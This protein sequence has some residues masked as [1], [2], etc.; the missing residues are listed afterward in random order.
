MLS[1]KMSSFIAITLD[2]D[3]D[4]ALRLIAQTGLAHFSDI[5]QSSRNL[6]Q[7]LEPVEPSERFYYLSNLLTRTTTLI[8]DMKVNRGGKIKNPLKVPEIPEDSYLESIETKLK[9]IEDEFEGHTRSLEIAARKEDK[10]SKKEAKKHIKELTEEKRLEL[11]GWEELLKREH[12]LEETKTLFYKTKRTYIMYGWIP[13]KKIKSLEKAIAQQK[14]VS[15]SIEFEAHK[16]KPES[17]HYPADVGPLEG[18]VAPEE[19]IAPPTKQTN[20]RFLRSFQNLT[21]A[22]GLPNHRE[23]DP[24]WFMALGFPIIFG[25]MFGDIGHGLLL[26][27]FAMIGMIAKRRNVDAGEMINYFIQGSGLIALIALVSVFFGVLY[28]EFLGIDITYLPIYQALKYSPFGQAMKNVLVNLF[29]FF[30]FDGGVNWFLDPHSPYNLWIL[31]DPHG[32]PTPI[33]FSAFEMPANL[34]ANIAN[35][36]WILFVLSIII[37]FIHLSIAIG[38]DAINK[39][40]HRDWKHAIFGPI[41]WLYFLWG[42]A[43]MI[44]QFGINF[45]AWPLIEMLIA[46]ILPAVIMFLGGMVAFGF[47]DGFMEGLERLIESISNTISYSRILAL[48]MAHAGFAKT[49]IFLAG[50]TGAVELFNILEQ[51]FPAGQLNFGT[52][53]TFIGMIILGTVFVLLMEGLLSF[54]HTLRLHWVEAY[55]KFYAGTGYEYKPLTLPQKWTTTPT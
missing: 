25:L 42:L 33:W 31:G 13:T 3:V 52:F 8:N 35:P 40:R 32:H 15:L 44:F 23:I 34:P 28:G 47:M 11:L 16:D 48:N 41:I 39:L 17:G 54:I 9:K 5:K 2:F 53:L 43:F 46:L 49:F 45:M 20:P 55:L 36:T 24:A 37:G 4:S 12:S 29:L 27:G 26:F 14:Q 30:D 38:F 51:L 1:A 18:E 21:N 50:F 22:F 6:S 10:A 7:G 19:P